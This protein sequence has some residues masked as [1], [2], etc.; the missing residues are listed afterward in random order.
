MA[1]KKLN[2]DRNGV[3]AQPRGASRNGL[4]KRP[5]IDVDPIKIITPFL[6]GLAEHGSVRRIVDRVF[7]RLPPSF[8]N[9]YPHVV[10][11]LVRTILHLLTG[12]THR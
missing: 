12:D 9:W 4:D 2:G 3:R 10:V 11:E 6:A 7:Q 5:D 8:D 1:Q